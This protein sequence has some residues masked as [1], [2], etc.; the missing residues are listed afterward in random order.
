MTPQEQKTIT[1]KGSTIAEYG[2]TRHRSRSV[3]GTV[4][5]ARWLIWMVNV[6][7]YRGGR[8]GIVVSFVGLFKHLYMKA[9]K[10]W[11]E[12]QLGKTWDQSGYGSWSVLRSGHVIAREEAQR[13]VQVPTIR[14]RVKIFYVVEDRPSSREGIVALKTYIYSNLQYPAE[15]EEGNRR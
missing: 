7:S 3:V 9:F 8:S 10:N 11:K 4:H 15:I 2:R 14:K 1:G 12:P 5:Q 13:P 6:Y